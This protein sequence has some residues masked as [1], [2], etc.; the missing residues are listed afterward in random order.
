MIFGAIRRRVLL[1]GVVSRE[2][3]I[4]PAAA[5]VRGGVAEPGVAQVVSG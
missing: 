4:I 2:S 1:L 5:A 3:N